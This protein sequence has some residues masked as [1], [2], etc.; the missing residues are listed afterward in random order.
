[1]CRTPICSNPAPSFPPRAG[2]TRWTRSSPGDPG[3]DD[4]WDRLRELT[5]PVLVAN[6]PH[7]GREPPCRPASSLSSSVARRCTAGS[8]SSSAD[9]LAP[10]RQARPSPQ[11]TLPPP[12][13]GRSGPDGATCRSSGRCSRD[14]RRPRRPCAR[15]RSDRARDAETPGVAA[16]SHAVRLQDSGITFQLP[17]S[18]KAPADQLGTTR[19]PRDA[20]AIE[21]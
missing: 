4:A 18:T 6:G 13:P 17:G 5:R 10:R 8:A 1:M 9:P 14:H 21:S 2:P 11:R 3:P 12:C 15:P 7:D 20:G 19:R 16:P